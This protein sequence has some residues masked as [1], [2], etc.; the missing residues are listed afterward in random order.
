MHRAWCSA[1]RAIA[2]FAAVRVGWYTCL[3]PREHNLVP[4][5]PRT[6]STRSDAV[7]R[8]ATIVCMAKLLEDHH[9]HVHWPEADRRRG[10]C[11]THQAI[12][13]TDQARTVHTLVMHTLHTLVMISAW[14]MDTPPT[15]PPLHLPKLP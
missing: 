9:P 14:L 12:F 5:P 13:V 1:L 10:S 8:A 4:S 15:P 7:A 11:E 6:Q 3:F 2:A